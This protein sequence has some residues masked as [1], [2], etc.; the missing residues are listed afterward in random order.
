ME[1]ILGRLM[2][3]ALSSDSHG[4]IENMIDDLAGVEPA[5]IVPISSG[6]WIA[7]W[8]AGGGIAAA[9][10]LLGALY[11]GDKTVQEP[12]NGA[13]VQQMSSNLI[14][15]SE[16]DRVESVTDEGLKANADGSAMRAVR[17]K[18]V[19]TNKVLDKESGMIIEIREPREELLLTP[20]TEF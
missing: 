16:T 11:M 14:V 13:L 9:L 15:V 17:L 1:A 10:G 3:P 8:A 20:I 5:K 19:E 2:P 18:A 6:G 7:R 12:R 4:E